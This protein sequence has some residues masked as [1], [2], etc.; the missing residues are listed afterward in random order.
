MCRGTNSQHKY[1]YAL[2]F[3]RT[4]EASEIHEREDGNALPVQTDNRA[5]KVDSLRDKQCDRDTI[6]N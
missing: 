5:L 4:N 2:L 6:K 1:V 3:T